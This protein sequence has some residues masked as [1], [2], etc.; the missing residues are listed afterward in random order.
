MAVV[1][2]H[3]ILLKPSLSGGQRAIGKELDG[4]AGKTGEQAG[5]TMG[6]ALGKALKIGA[7]AIGGAAVTGIGV[8]LTKGFGRLKAIEQAQATLT[9]LGHSAQTVEQIMQ[10]T[11]AAV[12][13]TAFGLGEAATV[14]AQ[15]VASGIKPG[16]DLQNTLTLVG[17]AATIAGVGIN[18]MGAIFAKA[19]ASNKVQMDIINQLHDA[20]VPALQLIATE[21]GVTAEE[22]S[23]M[24]SKG[25]VDFATFQRAMEQ[26][27]GG[28]AQES[29]KTLTGAFNN[30]MAAIGRFGANLIQDIYPQLTTFFNGFIEWMGPVEELGKTIGA[31]L[32]DGLS[33]AT[34]GAQGLYDLIVGGDFTSKLREAFGFEEDHP[35]VGF[36][37][38][39]RDAL[40]DAGEWVVR[41][42]DW[43]G[44]L[45]VAIGTAT[46]A[47][48]LHKLAI[49]GAAA[50]QKFIAGESLIM[51]LVRLSQWF[52][53]IAKAQGIATAAQWLF[54]KALG[55]NPIGKIITL[56]AALVA[57]LVW[58]FTQTETGQKIV[59]AVWGAI[60]AAVAAV[61]DWFQGTALPIFQAVWEGILTAARAVGDWFTSTLLP[62]F[63][64]VWDGI[65]NG[66]V[67]LYD[68]VIAPYLGFVMAY[69]QAVGE[70]FKLVWE[71]VLKP[72]FDAIGTVVG[73]LWEHILQP[74]FYNISQFALLAFDLVVYAWE[75]VLK[76]A[77]E[78]L[79]SF[80][81]GLWEN[82]VSFVFTAISLGWQALVTGTKAYWENVLRPVFEAVGAVAKWLW[83][84]ILSPTFTWISDAWQTM[85]GF[86]VWYWE[87]R[88]RPVL[89]AVGSWVTSMWTQYIDPALK[90]I[91]DAWGGMING[92]KDLW[93]NNLKPVFQAFGDFVRNT[94]VQ[95][96]E[97]AVEL[98]KSAWA[99]L[100]NGLRAPINWV[101]THVWNDGIVRAFNAVANEI[102]STAKLERAGLIPAFAKGGHHKGGW[103]LV[104]EEGPELVNFSQPGRVYTAAQT[105]QALAHGRDLTPAQSR[106][107]AG[108]S[109]DEAVAPMG[110]GF[111]WGAAGDEFKKRLGL[112]RI[113]GTDQIAEGTQWVVGNLAKA[114]KSVMDAAMSN[115]SMGGAFGQITKD[116]ASKAVGMVFGWATK[117]DEATVEGASGAVYDGKAGPIRR[118]SSG[119][120]TSWYGPRWGRH[121]AGIDF[122]GGGVTR[123]ALDGV[124]QRV[125]WNIGPGRT[126]YGIL[127]N[128]GPATWTYHG[129]NPVGG[130]RVR[131]GQ[132]VR[133]GQAV[134]AEGT[135]GNVTGKHLHWELH[136]GRAWRDTN[137]NGLF[138]DQGG[139]LPPG[140]SMVLNNTGKDE[141]VFND[142]QLRT[143]DAAVRGG[144]PT[145][146]LDLD[147]LADVL[148][149][150]PLR[151]TIDGRE[152][153]HRLESQRRA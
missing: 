128:H 87:D 78:A 62:I 109:Q 51:R 117:Q 4:M 38:A 113:L 21:M 151:L 49:E 36:V 93:E 72:V 102:D 152:L 77:F 10:N 112:G 64:A 149:G 100:A 141:W 132:Q 9:G 74:F 20:G 50:A 139:H 15:M 98:I 66:L 56:I 89:E 52:I 91:S 105:A 8:A 115:W 97:D 39:A 144:G 41:N 60:Q 138:R 34:A 27:M 57:G 95:R 147:A 79:G 71:T 65:S 37:L 140:L 86:F 26:G 18:D 153:R 73:W 43:L 46:T 80:L 101:L 75:T 116:I 99:G 2:V 84:N 83:E 120:I 108:R 59:Q 119:G 67:W 114:A 85:I 142:R 110:D 61:V 135:T 76:P 94:I 35:F 70:V 55:A 53:G 7:G 63:Q 40:K 69:F 143:L 22:A 42:K 129:H 107:A 3:E 136:R 104:G 146:T 125:G 134:G 6:G 148:D 13:G 126:G 31:A 122:A 81:L 103:A 11:N 106:R 150:R 121:H 127:M 137:I 123:A 29:G 14:A 124:V 88:L 45:A 1:G 32:G 90:S 5:R 17:D 24:A 12:K 19:A 133:A 54:N 33:R 47:Y 30:S 23:K 96:I 68:N 82:V 25:E 92:I 118:P 58:F 131:P 145:P 28:A 111:N 48:L 16:Q 130:V 44:G